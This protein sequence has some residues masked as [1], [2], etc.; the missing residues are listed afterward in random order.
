[1]SQLTTTITHDVD[2][3]ER[4]Q[5]AGPSSDEPAQDSTADAASS[6]NQQVTTEA[7]ATRLVITER[8]SRRRVQLYTTFKLFNCY[9]YKVLHQPTDIGRRTATTH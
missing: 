4:D 9:H 2:D 6:E 8:S 5:P 3:A 7:T 1:M